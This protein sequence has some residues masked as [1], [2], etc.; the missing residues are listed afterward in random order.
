MEIALCCCQCR[1][2]SKLH[3]TITESLWEDQVSLM[4]IHLRLLK[5]HVIPI[6]KEK[7]SNRFSFF[8]TK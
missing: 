1:L 6:F 4:I 7:L 8:E 3:K 2:F 5:G